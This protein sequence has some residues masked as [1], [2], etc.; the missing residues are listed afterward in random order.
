VS[1][2]PGLL[3]LLAEP[4]TYTIE[5]GF[6]DAVGSARQVEGFSLDRLERIRDM[7]RWHFWFAGRRARLDRLLR[8]QLATPRLILDVGCGTGL[9]LELLGRQHRVVGTD[10]RGEGLREL[11][12]RDPTA[13][14]VRADATM[15]PFRDEV[16]DLV[17]LLDVLEHLPDGVVLAEVRRVLRPGGL[18]AV[19]VPA[20]PGLWSGRDRAAGHL[21]RYTR[22]G[23][24]RL[25]LDGGLEVEA[26]G[27]YQFFLLPLMVLTRLISRSKDRP[28]DLE[29]R[30]PPRLNRLLAAVNRFE[31]ALADRVPMPVGSS[32][33]ALARKPD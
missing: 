15:L 8:R 25:L 26:L 12:E 16:F 3:A 21:R 10:L 19:T 30:P 32:L 2:P 28:A 22:R 9:M 6:I 31:A 17:L 13:W 29:E 5:A 4:D 11:A 7:E 20:L 1:A 27:F 14:L 18:L 24:E 33:L 23:L